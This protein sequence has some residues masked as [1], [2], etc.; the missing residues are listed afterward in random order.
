MAV[1]FG[2]TALIAVGF[3]MEEVPVVRKDIFLNL[4]IIGS[5]WSREV[6]PE[7]NPF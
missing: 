5:Y 1:G 7:D 3:L 2:A 4:P 6:A